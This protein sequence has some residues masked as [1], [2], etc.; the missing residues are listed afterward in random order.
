[1]FLSKLMVCSQENICYI[2]QENKVLNWYKNLN[3]HQFIAF[4]N[5]DL[6]WALLGFWN[7]ICS[8]NKLS[9][10]HWFT[11]ATRITF[12]SILTFKPKITVI[13]F[14]IQFLHPQAKRHRS[15]A[16]FYVEITPTLLRFKQLHFF[17]SKLTKLVGIIILDHKGINS[18][19]ELL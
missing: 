14:F 10:H 8:S 13:Q 7:L 15:F 1:M 5:L 12:R 17:K 19:C 18:K 6:S 11:C 4:G 2:F 16:S 3:I 9:S